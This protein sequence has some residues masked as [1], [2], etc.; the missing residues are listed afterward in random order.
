MS[1]PNDPAVVAIVHKHLNAMKAEL[2]DLVMRPMGGVIFNSPSAPVRGGSAA[3]AA[4]ARAPPPHSARGKT[5]SFKE[6]KVRKPALATKPALKASAAKPAP[7][8]AAKP[9]VAGLFKAYVVEGNG[10]SPPGRVSAERKEQWPLYTA[11]YDAFKD[12]HGEDRARRTMAAL[13]DDVVN[14]DKTI[15]DIKELASKPKAGRSLESVLVEEKE[16][17]EEE[18]EEEEEEDAIE[19]DDDDEDVIEDDDDDDDTPAGAPMTQAVDE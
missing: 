18:E 6:D 11:A 16:E 12:K 13:C 15:D 3:R 1:L 9:T 8:G 17:K 19:S 5:V 14:G 2:F 7:G 4:L 10:G